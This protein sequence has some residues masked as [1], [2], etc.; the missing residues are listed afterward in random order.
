MVL[1]LFQVIWLLVFMGKLKEVL[2]KVKLKKEI[3][4]LKEKPIVT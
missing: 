4:K 1:T 3:F 2:F